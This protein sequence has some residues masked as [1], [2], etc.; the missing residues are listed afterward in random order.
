[1]RDSLAFAPRNCQLVVVD[2]QARLAPAMPAEARAWVGATLAL[3]GKTARLLG[4]PVTVT[5]HVPERIGGTE[6]EVLAVF[7][8]P[9]VL[10]KIHFGA[11][12]EDTFLAHVAGLGRDHV[13]VAGMEAHVCVLQT[14]LGLKAR[15][16]R[17]AMIA[18]ASCSRAP[19]DEKVALDRAR[20]HGI[21]PVTAEMVVFEWLHRA[22]HPARRAV[23]DAIKAR[24]A[25]RVRA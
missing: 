14:A 1:M 17:V 18:D 11:A 13:L 19:L 12:N 20:F 22:D 24:D 4:V 25:L 6:P 3:L 8:A 2:V 7:D 23:I 15:G 5:E 16:Y 21:E 9:T 10:G